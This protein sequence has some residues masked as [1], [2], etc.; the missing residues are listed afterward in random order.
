MLQY[1]LTLLCYWCWKLYQNVTEDKR[2]AFVAGKGNKMKT[3][4][5]IYWY[6]LETFF[7]H[8][9]FQCLVFFPITKEKITGK[10]KFFTENFFKELV[11]GS[12]PQLTK[13]ICHLQ[14][15]LWQYFFIS[16]IHHNFCQNFSI[17]CRVRK[18]CSAKYW[19]CFYWN[20]P[21][22]KAFWDQLSTEKFVPVILYL[23]VVLFIVLCNFLLQ[24]EYFYFV[25]FCLS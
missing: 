23:P 20:Y 10:K 24:L 14:K 6:L 4:N 5:N 19:Y 11:F 13:K 12:N 2:N 3:N 8:L 25:E 18:L 7:L 22:I 1:L 17:S 15:S 9:C 16:C 21:A